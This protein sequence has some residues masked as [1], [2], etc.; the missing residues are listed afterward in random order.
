MG[1]EYKTHPATFE[2][3]CDSV[4][5]QVERARELSIKGEVVPPDEMVE[6]TSESFMATLDRIEQLSDIV[7]H[8]A[9]LFVQVNEIF[10][11]VFKY[12]GIDIEKII[13]EEIPT[14]LDW[15]EDDESEEG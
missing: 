1:I 9:M 12:L 4:R 7:T 11:W 3:L 15:L 14:N 10:K 6:L 5:G 8:Q 2:E 13:A